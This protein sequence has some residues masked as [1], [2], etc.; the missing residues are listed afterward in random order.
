MSSNQGS[1]SLYLP[2][3]MWL[4][5][6][7]DFEDWKDNITL[8]LGSKGLDDYIK[9]KDT[10]DTSD[11]EPKESKKKEIEQR[12]ARM[13]CGISIRGSI[14]EG[15]AAVIKGVKDPAEMMK[16][17]DDRYTTKGLNLKQKYLTEY[18]TLRVEH[19]DSIGAFIDQFKLLKTKLEAVG[20]K[21]PDEVYTI[22]FIALL[23]VQY[24][25]WADRQ[26]SSARSNPPTLPNLVSDILDESRKAEKATT[27][28]YSGK[29]VANKGSRGGGYKGAVKKCGYC[30]KQG[31]DVDS[32]WAK[33]P[34]QRPARSSAPRGQ[35]QDEDARDAEDNNPA[36]P[37]LV[38]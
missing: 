2:K 30:S 8:L 10:S 14:H 1:N 4:T 3:P 5:D 11:P 37:S 26:R 7:E 20:L 27:A 16:L 38:V 6:E 19:F 21:E 35:R 29:P 24:P 28:L 12:M 34:E 15:P 22:D 17:L 25:I 31:H 36:L 9:P 18:R 33:H 13:T 23:D 32:C